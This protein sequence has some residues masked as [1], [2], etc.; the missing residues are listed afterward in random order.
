MALL[1]PSAGHRNIRGGVNPTTTRFRALASRWHAQARLMHIN[2]RLSDLEDLLP[3]TVH[4]DMMS[5]ACT[6]W[7]SEAHADPVYGG[8][9]MYTRAHNTLP[10]EQIY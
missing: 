9:Q 2:V 3:V 8:A 10:S 6:L 4:A 7:T 1:P 5:I